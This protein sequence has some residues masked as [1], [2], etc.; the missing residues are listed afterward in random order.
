[1]VCAI[2]K[3]SNQR[4]VFYTPLSV[5]SRPWEYVSMDNLTEYPTTKH[6]HDA[7]VVVVDIFSKMA[8]L[9]P[10]NNIVTMQQTTQ[11]F[12]EHV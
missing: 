11:L 5:P 6:Q 7:I 4:Q 9:V 1:M 3:L 2:V 12:F 10:C 8:I